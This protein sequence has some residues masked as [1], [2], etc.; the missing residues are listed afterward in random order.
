MLINT[1]N[2][3]AVNSLRSVLIRLVLCF[4]MI[5]FLSSCNK[6]DIAG[7]W[8]GKLIE[9]KTGKPVDVEI[10]LNQDGDNVVGDFTIKRLNAKL[11]LTGTIQKDKFAFD[12]ELL[13]GLQIKFVGI[14]KDKFIDGDANVLMKGPNIGTQTKALRLEATRR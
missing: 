8:N 14:A 10:V 7:K 13:N 4:V 2:A 9:E 12:T 3:M 11:R 5:L 1:E 6:V